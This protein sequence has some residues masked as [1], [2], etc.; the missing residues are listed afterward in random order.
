MAVE[1]RRDVV[2]I[3]WALKLTFGLT[4]IVAGLDKFTN[5][6]VLWP[7][8]IAPAFAGM[9]PF[10]AQ[11]FMYLV[12]VTEIVAGIG[13]LLSPWTRVFAWIVAIWLWCIALDLIV[14]GFYDIAVR[15]LVMSVG[16]LCLAR[17]T[18]LVPEDV[19]RKRVLTPARV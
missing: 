14:A 13:V 5:L 2:P 16:A 17:V 15:D 12:G 6:L 7:K 3:F 8:Y 9:I 4:P 18:Q 10:S 11:G 19:A 1:T